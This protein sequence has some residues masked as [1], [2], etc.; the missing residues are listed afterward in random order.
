[1]DEIDPDDDEAMDAQMEVSHQHSENFKEM[2]VNVIKRLTPIFEKLDKSIGFMAYIHP[3]DINA[4][5][6]MKYM[7]MTVPDDVFYSNFSELKEENA[8]H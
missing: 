7:R 2:L 3:H 1:M 5:D 8:L 6:T 4:K